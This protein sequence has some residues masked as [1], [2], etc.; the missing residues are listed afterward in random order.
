MSGGPRL[1]LVRLGVV[2]GVDHEVTS[3]YM[4]HVASRARPTDQ[5]VIPWDHLSW[6]LRWSQTGQFDGLQMAA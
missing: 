6:P 5:V 4:H 1:A 2:G 3:D